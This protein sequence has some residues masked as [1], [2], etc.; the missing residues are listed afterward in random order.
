MYNSYKAGSEAYSV[1]VDFNEAEKDLQR[2]IQSYDDV[3]D[4]ACNVICGLEEELEIAK[5]EFENLEE[6]CEKLK[7]QLGYLVLPSP[8]LP[9]YY[10]HVLKA[11]QVFVSAA[12][13]QIIKPEKV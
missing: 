11:I 9:D 2:G 6:E 3:I 7:Q 10:H 12:A 5:E 1:Q 4:V 13:D 8:D